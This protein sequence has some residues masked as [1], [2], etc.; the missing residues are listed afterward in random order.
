MRKSGLTPA[1][2]LAFFGKAIRTN[3]SFLKKVKIIMID[4]L[5]NSMVS[6]KESSYRYLM[7]ESTPL[8]K[9]YHSLGALTAKVVVLCISSFYFGYTLSD[10]A[11]FSTTTIAVVIGPIARSTAAMPQ[12]QP[13]GEC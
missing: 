7:L 1:N 11:T 8:D 13:S 4:D 2:R 5:N 10:L 6:Q 12:K 3:L 9:T